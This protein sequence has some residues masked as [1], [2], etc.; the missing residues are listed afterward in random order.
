MMKLIGFR[1]QNFRSVADSGYIRVDDLTALVGRNESGKSNLLLA[2]HSLNPPGGRKALSPIKDFPRDRRLAECT[3]ETEVVATRWELT[4]AETQALKDILGEGSRITEVD[5]GRR[6]GKASLW[7]GLLGAKAPVVADKDVKAAFRKLDPVIVAEIGRGAED[8]RD[9]AAAAWDALKETDDV[10]DPKAWAARLEA[11]AKAVRAALGQAGIILG[12]AA[13]ELLS[14]LEEKAAAITGF[15]EALQKA[16]NAVAG[17]VPLFIYVAD[18]PELN[19]HQDI[20]S[21]MHRRSQGLE[22]DEA[23]RNFQKLAK[24]ADFSAEKLNSLWQAG[25]HETRNQLLNR[26]GALVSKEIRRLWKDRSLKVRF[27]VDGN[28]LDTLI[29]D[30]NATYDVEVNLDDRSR[31]FRWFFSF[32]ISFAADT[33]G[34]QAQGA[35]L[36]LDEPGLYLHAKSQEDLLRHFRQDFDNQIVYTTHSPFMIPAD[37]LAVVRTV[38]ITQE[39][40]TTVTNDPTGDSRTLF[41]L[42][43]ALGYHVSQTLFIGPANLVVEGITDFWI[44][45][46]VSSHLRSLGKTALPQDMVIT[47]VG[48]A[49]KVSYMVALLSSQQ[50]GVLVLLDD[51]KAG[52]EAQKELVTSRLVRDNAVIFVSEAF[53]EPREA[54]I[55]DLVDPAVY[56]ELVRHTYR[57]DLKGKTL[58]LN[59]NVPRIVKRFEMAFAELGLEF[60]K[61]R[62][63]REF[64]TR[65]ATEPEKMVTPASL[66]AFEALFAAIDG[67]HGRM[68]SAAA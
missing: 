68:R 7:I 30:P 51:E 66:P 26:A 18:F 15:D 25:D 5:V 9:A 38:N 33:N 47:P 8:K 34:G 44:L 6:Y 42:Q 17:W 59:T 19:G 16:R 64:L 52:R 14:G 46:S 48:G 54:D 22:L 28:H 13:D 37:D 62:P 11:G 53:A 58:K 56:E 49:G 45:S 3:D 21:F 50:L 60:N 12:D 36:L 31:G 20:A 39:A 4:E 43:A 41:P 57:K 40:G 10:S 35:I 2:L 63:A 24:V 29:S 27:N 61:T 23:E 32:Y 1:V 55:E 65:M 67:R